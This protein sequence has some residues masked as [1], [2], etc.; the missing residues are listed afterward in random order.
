MNLFNCTDTDMARL[1]NHRSTKPVAVGFPKA[2]CTASAEGAWPAG[3]EMILFLDFDGTLHPDGCDIDK[4]F[5][6][7][8]LIEEV[9]RDF[10]Y[11]QV[12]VSSSWGQ[13]H[14]LAELRE[15]FSQDIKT[16]IIDVTPGR[17]LLSEIPTELWHFVR[18]AQCDSWIRTNRP[19]V[20]WLAIDDQA[21]RFD[22]TSP[23]VLLVDGKIG[24]TQADIRELRRRLSLFT[25]AKESQ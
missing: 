11:I 7:A 19:G 21:W 23:N 8:P 5:C 24:I 25:N 6:R 14:P 18:E 16:Q 15:F 13:V 12:V 9:L 2:K 22:P 3:N 4:F 1:T 20:P 10:P 17:L